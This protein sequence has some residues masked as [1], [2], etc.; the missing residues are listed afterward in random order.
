[1]SNKVSVYDAVNLLNQLL[2]MDQDAISELVEIRVKINDLVAD[3][4]TVT[5]LPSKQNEKCS[6][7]LLGVLNGLFGFN[8]TDKGRIRAVNDSF[9]SSKIIRFEVQ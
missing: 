2:K 8:D 4:P 9:D 1:M 3:H 7:G 5:V 6:L